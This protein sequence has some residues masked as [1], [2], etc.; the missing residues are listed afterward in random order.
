MHFF[1]FGFPYSNQIVGKRAALFLRGYWEAKYMLYMFFTRCASPHDPL[2][3]EN[4]YNSLEVS[5][6]SRPAHPAHIFVP[7][8]IY[9]KDRIVGASRRFRAWGLGFRGLGA[10]VVLGVWD[11]GV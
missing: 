3:P 8:F 11:V 6:D 10:S 4:P 9:G 5:M 7:S 1:P 2:R